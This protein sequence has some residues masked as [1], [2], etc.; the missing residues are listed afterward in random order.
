MGTSGY[1]VLFVAICVIMVVSAE[2]G[3]D[4]VDYTRIPLGEKD[5]VRI[6]VQYD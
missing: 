6:F 1:Y 2:T 4:I 3:I 5:N